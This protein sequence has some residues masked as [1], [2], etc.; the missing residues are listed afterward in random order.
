[1]GREKEPISTLS[2]RNAS[3]TPLGW[4]KHSRLWYKL[5]SEVFSLRA[6]SSP[7]SSLHLLLGKLKGSPLAKRIWI[8]E[9]VW[10]QYLRESRESNKPSGQA[11]YEISLQAKWDLTTGG[12]Q[13]PH[14]S[15]AEGWLCGGTG[16]GLQDNFVLLKFTTK[17]LV[18]L[19]T[20][21]LGLKHL[22]WFSPT[23]SASKLFFFKVGRRERRK[24]RLEGQ[25]IQGRDL[26]DC[27]AG[28]LFVPLWFL[29]ACEQVSGAGRPGQCCSGLC[30]KYSLWS[31]MSRLTS[32]ALEWWDLISWCNYW[33]MSDSYACALDCAPNYCAVI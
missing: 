11:S 9:L 33:H 18:P 4:L 3:I 1:M 30:C 24:W 13:L 10:T 32:L 16:K 8:P 31:A 29:C 28:C 5:I 17:G 14:H 27:P 15:R 21:R 22:Q 2:T 20:L 6:T 12:K 23:S 25:D 26:K 19:L 7:P